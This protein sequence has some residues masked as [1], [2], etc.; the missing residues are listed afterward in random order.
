MMRSAWKM[1]KKV[2]RSRKMAKSEQKS[3]DDDKPEVTPRKRAMKTHISAPKTFF[4][5][6]NLLLI[7]EECR[8]SA[9]MDET[10]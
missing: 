5:Y 4:N 9:L 2:R 3:P 7:V 8:Q 10:G 1:E 6:K